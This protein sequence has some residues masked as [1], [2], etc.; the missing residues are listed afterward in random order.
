MSNPIPK[1]KI[2]LKKN[3]EGIMIPRGA[4]ITIDGNEIGGIMDL[5]FEIGSGKAGQVTMTLIGDIDLS[6]ELLLEEETPTAP[7]QE[8][9]PTETAIETTATPTTEA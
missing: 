1:I 3:S 9:P 5:K 7:T 2:S 4:S 8:L 6:S